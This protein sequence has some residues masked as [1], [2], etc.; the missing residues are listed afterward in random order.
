VVYGG[1]AGQHPG[2][3][4]P[5]EWVDA[6][7]HLSG[8]GGRLLSSHEG[9][10]RKAG[11]GPLGSFLEMSFYDRATLRLLIEND[12]TSNLDA[13]FG[14]TGVTPST[15]L[16]IATLFRDLHECLAAELELGGTQAGRFIRAE[17]GGLDGDARQD[18]AITML[19]AEDLEVVQRHC[20][21]FFPAPQDLTIKERLAIRFARLLIEGH[22]VAYPEGRVFTATLNGLDTA[23]LREVLTTPGPAAF[24]L[25]TDLKIGIGDRWLSLG[26]AMLFHTQGEIPDRAELLTALDAGTA[27]GRK[28]RVIPVDG[29]HF[30]AVLPSARPG[31]D[32]EPLQVTPL[33]LPGLGCARTL[34]ITVRSSSQDQSDGRAGRTWSI[35]RVVRGPAGPT[36]RR[37][38]AELSRGQAPLLADRPAAAL[39]SP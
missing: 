32:S 22:C 35:H 1:R 5:E 10:V 17:A 38:H 12:Q 25:N 30:R 34:L 14:F 7:L 6:T 39:A 3:T 18:L 28:L 20:R 8:S 29:Q 33:G 2:V 15:V 26:R 31:R 36:T 27:D 21:R 37:S 19:L 4:I 23:A 16:Q 13:K 24:R 11:S 9:L